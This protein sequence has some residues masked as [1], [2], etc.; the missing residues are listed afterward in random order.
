M[1]ALSTETIRRTR[2]KLQEEDPSLAAKPETQA[3]RAN[4]QAHW[5][6]IFTGY[7]GD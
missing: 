3:R 1:T 7:R 6:E 5:G 4:A 2:Q